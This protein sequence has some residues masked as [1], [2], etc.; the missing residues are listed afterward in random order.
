MNGKSAL[1]HFG[2]FDMENYGDLLYPMIFE[3]MLRKRGEARQIQQFSLMGSESLQDSGYSTRPLQQLFS[4]WRKQPHRLIVGGGD[5]LRTDWNLVAS[6][7][8]SSR[9]P[10]KR[11]TLRFKLRQWRRHLLKQP[12]DEIGKFRYQYMNYSAVGPFIIEPRRFSNPKSVAY[13]SCGVPFPFEKKVRHLVARAINQ[14]VFVYV[15]DRQSRQTLVNAGVTREIH[16]APDL[17]V[18]L[19]DF[20]DPSVE[21]KKGRDLLQQAGVDIR[22]N[23]LCVQSN[24]QPPETNEELLQQLMAYQKRTAC[25]VVLLPLGQ[26]HGDNAY[27]RQLAQASGGIFKYLELD[28]IFAMIATLAACDVFIG[29]SMHGNITAFSFGIPHLFGPI[30]AAKCEGFL[31]VVNLPLELKLKSWTEINQ[32]LDV[33]TGMKGQYF[34]D[35]ASVAKQRV[36]QTFDLLVQAVANA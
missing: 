28:S 21:R 36:N 17:I 4:F 34:A 27:L 18:A 1:A 6:H 7:Y 14:A 2:A 13:C 31:D 20:F 16:V 5:V 33:V 10:R 24:P 23:I 29:T 32:K 15:R 9:L 22:R 26:C 25:E 19:S 12:L 11:P 3:Q 8:Q 35:R 30:P